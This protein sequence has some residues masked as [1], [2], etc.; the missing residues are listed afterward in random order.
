MTAHDPQA[1]RFAV[2]VPHA[3]EYRRRVK[4]TDGQASAA[5]FVGTHY[6]DEIDDRSQERRDRDCADVCEHSALHLQ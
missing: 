5:T 4:T 2:H 3:L 1:A 6:E